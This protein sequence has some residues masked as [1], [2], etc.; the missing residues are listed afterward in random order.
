M[1]FKKSTAFVRINQYEAGKNI[2]K[3]GM[4]DAIA[5]ALG[6]EEFALSD[7]DISTFED[8]IHLFLELE[9]NLGLTIE[10]RNGKTCLCFDDER[11]DI[12]RLITYMNIWNS[13]KQELTG[14]ESSE[15]Y[16][17]KKAEY[18]CWKANFVTNAQNYLD[19]K[20][21]ELERCYEEDVEI[22]RQE[23]TRGKSTSDMTKALCT[24]VESGVHLS[25]DIDERH[26]RLAFTFIVNELRNPKTEEARR[27]FAEFLYAVKYI[28]SLSKQL[29]ELVYD[30]MIMPGDT[31]KVRYFFPCVDVFLCVKYPVEDFIRFYQQNGEKNDYSRDRFTETHES[32]LKRYHWDF[33]HGLGRYIE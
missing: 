23:N 14:I 13:R 5:K 21:N 28:K 29:D 7:I 24:L 17:E 15:V 22:I 8:M 27:A 30:E 4:R 31:P 2:P 1:G 11:M 6:V 18:D 25:I 10:R 33:K 3:E 12:Q 26:D 20:L 16:A 32:E 9:D 19:G